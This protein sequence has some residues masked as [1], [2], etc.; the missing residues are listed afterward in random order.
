M[1]KIELTVP[2][3][4]LD[5]EERAATARRILDDISRGEGFS[6]TDTAVA[7]TAWQIVVH[8]AV[9]WAT[10]GD[11]QPVVKVSFPAPMLTD[12]GRQVFITKIAAAVSPLEPWI[13]FEAVPDGHFG[14]TAPM[15]AA[16]LIR[17]LRAA[18]KA[19]EAEEATAA[20]IRPGEATAI[21]PICGMTVELTAGAI[22]FE[23]DGESYAFCNQGC[24]A[25]FAE[26]VAV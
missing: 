18:M 9:A 14:V 22:T 8:E 19:E 6:P 24:K 5:E 15:R 1:M 12:E 26:Q 16:E 2:Q 17:G 25:A 23:H 20:P 7:R 3:G 4:M 21:D 11:A 13:Y 10:G